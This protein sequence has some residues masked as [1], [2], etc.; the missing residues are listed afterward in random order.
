MK[1]HPLD[2]TSILVYFVAMI[3]IGVAVMKRAS[4]GMDSSFLAGNARRHLVF[5]V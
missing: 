4:K 5:Q 2:I 1:Y 3:A